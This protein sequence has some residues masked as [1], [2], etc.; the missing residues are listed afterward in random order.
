MIKDEEE[1]RTQKR[2]EESED[3]GRTWSEMIRDDKGKERIG[4][5]K[6]VK[7]MRRMG[8]E[9]KIKD[10]GENGRR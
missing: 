6:R 9:L 7:M 10:D 2:E 8:N 4:E 3:E 1:E 5:W